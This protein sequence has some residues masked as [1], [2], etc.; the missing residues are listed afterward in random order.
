MEDE[1]ALAFALLIGEVN[2]VEPPG[3]VDVRECGVHFLLPIDP[4]EI[5]ALLFEG[6]WRKFM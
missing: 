4:P 3:G 5:D 1:R 2:V 6:W